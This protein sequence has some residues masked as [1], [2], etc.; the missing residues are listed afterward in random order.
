MIRIVKIATANPGFLIRP[1]SSHIEALTIGIITT[2]HKG[3]SE[4]ILGF[5]AAIIQL[6]KNR[7]AELV[8]KYNIDEFSLLQV[9]KFAGLYLYIPEFMTLQVIS[10]EDNKTKTMRNK[11]GRR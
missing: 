11:N 4:L 8:K 10:A 9:S 2:E 1:N 6:R 7:I 5:F 3:I